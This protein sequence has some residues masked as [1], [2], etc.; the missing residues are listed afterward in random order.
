MES[1]RTPIVSIIVPTYNEEMTIEDV[2]LGI[3][4]VMD[5]S[6]ISYEVIVVCD[7]SDKETLNRVLKHKSAHVKVVSYFPNR[8]K[9]FALKTGFAKS[10]GRFIVTIDSDGSHNPYDILRIIKLLSKGIDVVIGVR[11]KSDMYG[12]SYFR[13]LFNSL[14]NFMIKILILRN[15]SDSQSGL[16][17]FRRELLDL[18]K[19]RSDRY[20]IETEL[21]IRML[22]DPSVKYYEIPIKIKM[23]QSGKSNLSFLRDGIFILLTA[24]TSLF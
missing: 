24:F 3:N 2:L 19:I 6:G 14:V 1:T 15:I 4:R 12:T 16:R 5:N 13:G 7:G 8:G 22:K 17:G 9:G 18:Q 10:R 21:T 11:S 20:S 23:R